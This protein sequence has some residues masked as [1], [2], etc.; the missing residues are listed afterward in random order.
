L[1]AKLEKPTTLKQI[2]SFETDNILQN[3]K[4]RNIPSKNV[5]EH[6][7]VSKPI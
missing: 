4:Q 6:I 5:Y 1:F 7:F 2:K 3:D